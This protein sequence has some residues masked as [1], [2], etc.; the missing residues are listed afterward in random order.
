[1]PWPKRLQLESAPTRLL[2]HHTPKEHGRGVTA[3]DVGFHPRSCED[4]AIIKDRS[5][6]VRHGRFRQRNY[7]QATKTFVYL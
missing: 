1:M 2:K 3:S 5:D 6:L 7:I 4:G